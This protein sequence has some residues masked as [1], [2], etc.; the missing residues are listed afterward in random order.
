MTDAELAGTLTLTESGRSA[1]LELPGWYESFTGNVVIRT[2]QATCV[3]RGKPFGWFPYVTNGFPAAH[4][5]GRRSAGLRNESL[6]PD[7]ISF[8]RFGDD[9]EV[10]RVERGTR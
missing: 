4:Y 7:R 1:Y 9:P 6:D 8:K 5:S 10:Y 2:P 3:V